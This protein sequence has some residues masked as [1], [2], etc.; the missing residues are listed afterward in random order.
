M[1][2]QKLNQAEFFEANQVDGNLTDEQAMQ[3]L[4]LPEGDSATAAQSSDAPDAAQDDSTPEKVVAT[5]DTESDKQSPPVVLAR[6]GVHTI[7]Y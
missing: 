6:D 7:P 1:T 4:A 5:A 3:M 2:G